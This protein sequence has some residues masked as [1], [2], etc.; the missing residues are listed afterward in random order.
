MWKDFTR[1]RTQAIDHARVAVMRGC[2]FIWN[3][4]KTAEIGWRGARWPVAVGF[5]LGGS[6]AVGESQL[7]RSGQVAE[8]LQCQVEVVTYLF[9]A[10]VGPT[11]VAGMQRS[12]ESSKCLRTPK[13]PKLV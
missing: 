3:A 6:V 12:S 13:C 11:Y 2:S 5:D 4:R 9:G 1:F 7:N 8:L 10:V